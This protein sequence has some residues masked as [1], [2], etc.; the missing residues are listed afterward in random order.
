MNLDVETVR[1]AF[2]SPDLKVKCARGCTILRV[3]QP[4]GGRLIIESPGYTLSR[5]KSHRQ[6]TPI[7]NAREDRKWQVPY[8]LSDVGG[9]AELVEYLNRGIQAGLQMRDTLVWLSCDHME[10]A[11]VV[12]DASELFTHMQTATGVWV[13]AIPNP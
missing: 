8:Q 10:R 6:G 12:F 7:G 1:G 3:W 9:A 5:G 11:D 4:A 13:L 2:G